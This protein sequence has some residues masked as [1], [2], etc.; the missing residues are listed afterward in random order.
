[1][2][3]STIMVPMGDDR[4]RL[5]RLEIGAGLARR[6]NAF[7]DVLYI[8][9]PSSGQAEAAGR[10]G[11]LDLPAEAGAVGPN[12]IAQIEDEVHRA[13]ADISYSWSVGEGDAL[14][15]LTARAGFTDLVVLSQ[16]HP[17]GIEHEPLLHLP[18]RL[19][20]QTP[21]PALILPGDGELVRPG[22]HILVAWKNC[23]EAGRAV[24]DALPF[25][26]SA[27]RVTVLTVGF[28]DQDDAEPTELSVYLARHGV[29]AEF[30]PDARSDQEAGEGILA[31]AGE[32]EC[33]FIVMG[34]YGHSRLRD[35]VLGSATH[36]VLSRMPVP[37]LMSH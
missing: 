2:A 17:A 11:S 1:M 31:V 19:P 25:L 10:G 32:L 7:L 12:R 29:E 22:R 30:H 27:N 15:V 4:R 34:A 24:R 35:L 28:D 33:D 36:T 8:G 16:A 14:E 23:R 20:L 6:F 3:F 5:A 9:G 37:V 26:Q 13:C 21:C 18:D